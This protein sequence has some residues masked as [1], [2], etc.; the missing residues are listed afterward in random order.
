MKK[1]NI[2]HYLSVVVIAVLTATSCNSPQNTDN[3]NASDSLAV[4]DEVVENNTEDADIPY[5]VAQRYFVNN[6]VTNGIENPKI[7]T[8]EEF[9]SVFGAA[10][11]MGKDGIPTDIDFTKQYVIAVATPPTDVETTLEPVDLKKSANGEVVFTYK[12][13]TGQKQSYTSHASLAIIVDKAVTGNVVVN[14]VK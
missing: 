11:V 2:K 13:I 14:E 3:T 10:A 9:D 8:K 7:E 1:I 5:T 12:V 6:T 4:R